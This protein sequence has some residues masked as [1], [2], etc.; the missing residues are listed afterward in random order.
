MLFPISYQSYQEEKRSGT[1][2]SETPKAAEADASSPGLGRPFLLVRHRPTMPHISRTSPLPPLYYY[3]FAVVEPTLALFGGIYC[4]FFPE[5]YFDN[6]LHYKDYFLVGSEGGGLRGQI[7]TRGLGNCESLCW[8]HCQRVGGEREVEKRR[9]GGGR[10]WL[11]CRRNDVDLKLSELDSVL[12][13]ERA[14]SLTPLWETAD[15]SLTEADS[16]LSLSFSLRLILH[17][18]IL[19]LL[20]PLP[21]LLLPLPHPQLKPPQVP[22]SIRKHPRCFLPLSRSWRRASFACPSFPSSSPKI[23][24]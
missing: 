13:S 16:W 2:S 6:T 15:P 17:P 12:A 14:G 4:L 8:V 22:R 23:A 11:D 3:F 18:L 7:V 24:G 5:H 9:S 20:P 21:H 1:S 19:R 10:S